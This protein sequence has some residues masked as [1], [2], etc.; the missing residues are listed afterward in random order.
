[1]DPFYRP[2]RAEISLDAV[3]HNIQEFRA[4]LPPGMHIMAV[5]KADAYGHGSIEVAKQAVRSGASYIG[6]AFLDEALELRRADIDAPIL[7]LGYTPPEGVSVARE[8][9]VTLTVYS[10]DVLEALEGLPE[11]ELESKIHIKID[12]GMGRLGLHDE[13]EAIRFIDRALELKGVSVEALFTH[14]ARAD[15]TDK[16]RTKEQYLRMNSIVEHYRQRGVAFPLLHSGNSAAAMD[17]PEYCYNMVRLGIAMYG[18]YPSEE[19]NRQHIALMPALSFITGVVMVKRVPA[20]T[21]ISYGGIYQTKQE[22]LIATLPVGYADGYTRMLTGK[23]HVLVRGHKVP[24]VGRICMDQ[25]MI[26]VTGLDVGVGDEVVL[27]GKQGDSVLSADELAAH[28]GTINYEIT[29]MLSSRV[30]KVYIRNGERVNVANR[31][32]HSFSN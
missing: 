21:Q 28:L 32:L 12:T 17:I 30:P 13:K 31:L 5:V 25:C 24:I 8:H 2:T 27:I 23:A 4:A 19:V 26:N 29:C 18:L 14:Y 1:V 7:V 20:G 16:S 22:E 9:H 15:E 10:E 11:S 6:V 3:D